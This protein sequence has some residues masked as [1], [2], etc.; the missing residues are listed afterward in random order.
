MQELHFVGFTSNH[1]GLLLSPH[2]DATSGDYFVQID[3]YLAAAIEQ[4][5]DGQDRQKAQSG[6]GGEEEQTVTPPVTPAVTRP[7]VRTRPKPASD[8]SP[9]E[10]QARLRS[11]ASVAEVAEEARV[12]EDWVLRFADPI[13]A[14]QSR[15]VQRAL[16]LTFTKPRV[17]PSA[18]PLRNSV[19]WNLADQGALRDDEVFDAGWSAYNLHGS[20]W[21]VRFSFSAK[22]RRKLAEWEVDLRQGE[23]K[24]RN[25]VATDLGYV[26]PGRRRKPPPEEL[27]SPPPARPKGTRRMG[28]GKAAQKVS[29]NKA[30]ASRTASRVA[31]K[32]APNRAAPKKTVVKT[33]AAAKSA[34]RKSPANRTAP[35]RSAPKRPAPKKSAPKRPMAKKATAKKKK[36]TGGRKAVASATG[37]SATTMHAEWRASDPGSGEWSTQPSWSKSPHQPAPTAPVRSA[38]EEPAP[39]PHPPAPPPAAAPPA[40]E[41]LPTEPADEVDSAGRLQ[42]AL[43]IMSTPETVETEEDEGWEPLE[44]Q[45]RRWFSRHGRRGSRAGAESGPPVVTG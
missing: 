23:L 9:R 15:V 6:E 3:E 8:L 34:A 29:A 39:P 40:P 26:E 45:P 42:P 10:I 35:R 32:S 38:V 27:E 37:P 14:E 18:Q 4:R 30:R 12:D 28:S 21:V 19:R 13:V 16:Q 24:A 20:T 11:G 33:T 2:E 1:E 43:V 7:V 25:R 5:P 41:L 22:R 17:G 31:K 36:A 44:D